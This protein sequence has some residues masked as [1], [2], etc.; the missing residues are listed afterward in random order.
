[1]TQSLLDVVPVIPVVVIDDIRDAV[2]IARALVAGGLSVIELTL[3]TPV[4]AGRHRADRRRGPR[5]PRRRR[6]DR[7]PGAGQ[8]GRRAGAQFLVSPGAPRRC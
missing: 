8:A 1:M 6:H 5:D 7:R 2:P 4:G 3:R